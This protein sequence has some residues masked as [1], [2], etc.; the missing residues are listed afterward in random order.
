MQRLSSKLTFFYKRVFPFIWFGILALVAALTVLGPLLG[1]KT[2]TGSSLFPL[3]ILVFMAGFGYVIM[4]KMTFDLVDEVLDA[5]DALVVRN[6]DVEDHIALSNIINVSYTQF[7]NPP[8][9]TLSLRNPSRLGDRITFCPVASLLRLPFST[10]PVMEDLIKR[11]DAARR[12][13]R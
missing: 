4:K 12:G 7:A 6:A 2:T 11:V 10:I 5:G 3:V 13:A 1:G 8:R 9:A